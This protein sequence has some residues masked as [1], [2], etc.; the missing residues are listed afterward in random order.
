M[1]YEETNHGGDATD[2]SVLM[3]DIRA[4]RYEFI[5]VLHFEM[6]SHLC[7]VLSVAQK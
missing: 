3:I 4:K 1:T 7:S 2:F 5:K 6:K